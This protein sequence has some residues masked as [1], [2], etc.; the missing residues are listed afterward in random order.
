MFCRKAGAAKEI[1][2]KD[3]EK[4]EEPTDPPPKNGGRSC[5]ACFRHKLDRIKAK[6]ENKGGS[7]IQRVINQYSVNNDT[8]NLFL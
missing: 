2:C 7:H 1:V 3:H 4:K 5:Q 8:N 6:D